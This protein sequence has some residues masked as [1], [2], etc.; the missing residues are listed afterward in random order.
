[1]EPAPPLGPGVEP[2]TVNSFSA[3]PGGP[4]GCYRYSPVCLGRGGSRRVSSPQN[5]DV[6]S[7]YCPESSLP[8][9]RKRPCAQVSCSCSAFSGGVWVAKQPLRALGRTRGE[10]RAHPASCA[11]SASPAPAAGLAAG[12]EGGSGHGAWLSRYSGAVTVHVLR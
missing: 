7:Y 4:Q 11:G 6:K 1:M 3:V 5:S 10:A 9:G 12:A 8:G 2:G